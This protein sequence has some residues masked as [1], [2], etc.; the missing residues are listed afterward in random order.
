MPMF[1]TDRAFVNLYFEKVNQD[2]SYEYVNSSRGNEELLNLHADFIRS[3]EVGNTIIDYRKVI[4]KSDGSCDFEAV[5][6]VDVKGSIPSSL[7]R[8]SAAI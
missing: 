2:G 3:N 5:L 4:P 1:M 6:C 7:Q 8:L